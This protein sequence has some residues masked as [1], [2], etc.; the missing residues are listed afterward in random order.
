L[1]RVVSSGILDS[2][3]WENK[4]KERPQKEAKSRLRVAS[5]SDHSSHSHSAHPLPRPFVSLGWK[6]KRLIVS[7]DKQSRTPR[8]TDVQLLTPNSSKTGTQGE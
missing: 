2:P 7:D 6:M 1:R 3:L 8:H 4:Q 5:V